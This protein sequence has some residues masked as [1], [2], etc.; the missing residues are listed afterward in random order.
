MRVFC[1]PA[2]L[3]G[4]LDAIPSKSD[5]HRVLICAALAD[6]PTRVCMSDWKGED[7]IATIRCLEALGAS[8]RHDGTAFCV[9]P[10]QTLPDAPTLDCGESGSTLR[11]LLPVVAALGCGGTFVGSGRLPERPIGALLDAIRDGGVTVEGDRLPV[12]LAGKLRSGTYEVPGDISSQF[13][14]GFLLAFPLLPAGGTVAW[15]S[16]LESAGYV[17]MTLRAQTRF[18]VQVQSLERSFVV[19][20]ENGYRSPGC[21][22]V[23][24]DWSNMA[25]FLAAGALS[26]PVRVRGLSAQSPQR[27]RDAFDLLA[28]FGA[29]TTQHADVL[30]VQKVSLSG[31]SAIDVREIPDL[32]PILAIMA[33]FSNGETRFVNAARLRLKESDR[34]ESTARMLRALGATVHT[35]ADFLVVEGRHSLRGGRVD[36]DG[37]HRIA[38]AAAIAALAC[39][40]GAELC[41]AE[42]V[43]KSYP[44]FFDD[45]AELGGKFDVLDD[46]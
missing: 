21:V 41:G 15:K 43:N 20:P 35:G 19:P 40:E 17:D 39:E 36:C 30:T 23:E 31:L 9:T 6:A 46:R 42:A 34:I 2:S 7:I 16:A 38:M 24:G 37:D 32:M 14:T 13:V 1:H 22:Q 33:A 45:Y 5:A 28:R 26:G 11:F 25:F 18:A 4:Q 12:R 8:F 44:S 27:D 29:C 10:I 3:Q